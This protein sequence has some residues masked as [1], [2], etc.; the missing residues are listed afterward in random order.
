MSSLGASSSV[1]AVAES[2]PERVRVLHVNS[3]TLYGGVETILVT[4]ARLRDLCPAMEPHFALCHEGRLSRDLVE[5]GV[6]VYMLGRVRIS[7]PWT[8]W[9]ARRRLREILR[10]ERFDIVI[11]HMSWS[12]AVFGKAVRAEGTKLGFWAHGANAVWTWLDR[13]A[14]RTTPD[15]AIANSRF[16][17]ADTARLFPT[18]RR[19]VLYTPVALNDS[20]DAETLR[21]EIRRE[22]A[23]DDDTVVILQA[24]RMEAWKGH[25]LH[26]EALSLLKDS[27]S[28]WVCWIAGGAQRP[29]EADYLQR[30]RQRTAELGLTGRVQFLGQRSDVPRLLAGAD[31]FCQPNQ[32][33]EPFGIVF[34]EALW[35]GLPVVT[36]AMGG[37]VEIVDESCGL[38]VE[39][40]NPARLAESL[41]GLVESPELRS[42]LGRA[43]ATRARQL[44]DPSDQI[45]KLAELSLSVLGRRSRS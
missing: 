31:I 26:L 36:T 13:W 29:E 6:S 19:Q 21:A 44:C 15:V 10:R 11:C 5:A 45:K 20:P 12:L 38:L 28:A 35:A 9:R 41:R 22:Q 37:A 39:P 23:V 24:S 1:A 7:R 8:G 33:P 42:R 3:G 25:F 40:S 16:T 2:C 32:G 34:I 17:E 43:S 30:L 18:A 27:H 14:R 4:L